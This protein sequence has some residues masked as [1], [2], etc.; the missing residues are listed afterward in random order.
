LIGKTLGHYEINASLGRGGMGEVY[1]AR[2]T[3]LRREVAIKVL[4][5]ALT[6]DPERRMRFQR[7]AQTAAALSHPN[8]AVIHE[9]SEHEGSPFL[10]MELIEGQTLDE[11]TQGKTLSMKEW[12]HYA[13]PIAEAIAH[14]HRNGVVHRDLKPSN[15]MITEDG[16]V[17]LLDFG[18]AKLLE[19][20]LETDQTALDT[21]SQELTRAG[22]VIGTVAYMSPEQARGQTIDHRTDIFSLGVLLYQLA[23]GRLPFAGDSDIESLNATLTEDPPPLLE[24]APE[25]APEASRVVAKSMEKEPDRR[26][27]SAAEIV[28]DFRNLARDL[29][30]GRV[31]IAGTTGS[32]SIAPAPRTRPKWALPVV[33]LAVVAA[34][35]GFWQFGPG[36]GDSATT[37]AAAESAR[38]VVLPFENLGAPEDEY[39]AAGVTEEIIGRL[40]SV[41]D[42][43]V[44]ARS[45]AFQYDR[46]GKTLQQVGADFDVEYVLEGTVRW[47]RSGETN[48][49]R[50]APQLVRV[51][52]ATSIWGETYDS[53]MDDIF[54]VQSNIARQVIDALGVVL[55]GSDQSSLE[56]RPTENQDAYRA[57]LRGRDALDKTPTE[58]LAEEMFTRAVEL[59]PDF[60]LAWAGLSRAH[61]WRFH[62]GDKSPDRR[63]AALSAAQEA[64][65]LAPD[66]P[67]AMMAMG[68]YHYRCFRDYD[69]ALAQIER[70]A[71]NRPNDTDVLGWK[72]TIFK[73][74]GKYDEAIRLRERIME[75]DPMADGSARELGVTYRLMR[76][77]AKSIEAYDRAI[78]IA[79]DVA[80][81]HFRK[82][83]IYF[84]WKGTTPEARASLETMPS[85]AGETELANDAWFWLEYYE[86]RYEE[87]LARARSGPEMFADQLTLNVRAALEALCLEQLGRPAEANAA[88]QEAVD[89]LE[90]EKSQRPDDFRVHRD[91][92]EPLAALGR[93]DEALAAARRAIELMPMTTDVEAGP[94][95]L[96]SLLMA[97]LRL[98]QF[99]E[100][101]AA[102]EPLP[103]ESL[104]TVTRMRLDPRFESFVGLPRFAEFERRSN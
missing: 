103:R 77:Y 37:E 61:S 25:F 6:A 80:S 9:I 95:P 4:P 73:R 22:K 1:R 31:S 33:A 36:G 89:F 50:I 79:P 90:R 44:I 91:L 71:A 74:Q 84:A 68:L 67:E 12:L 78:A 40:A 65:R 19:P 35:I 57:Y 13:V 34:L 42:V 86:G 38:I 93:G 47:A 29:D 39:F 43:S 64:L 23:T 60:A 5:P 52:D 59:D 104:L 72:A 10:V 54:Q 55:M 101:F 14:A 24:T 87:A 16:R 45:S 7:E 62:G 3:K 17:K 11:A 2:D 53:S 32:T 30:T 63:D 69:R 8:I 81:P 56:S 26:Y 83:F 46:T 92:A 28:T 99:D 15:V 21:I 41:S 18:L 27:Q 88:W 51:N 97:H 94:A 58:P 20:D 76:E 102:L 70:A 96:E 85:G 66:A 82:A 75:L 100:A 48:R 98:G 49:V